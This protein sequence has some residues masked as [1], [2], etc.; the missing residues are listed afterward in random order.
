VPDDPRRRRGHCATTRVGQPPKPRYFRHSTSG[1]PYALL[2]RCGGGERGRGTDAGARLSPF[3]RA[4][5]ATL[6]K[7]DV[8]E[9][10]F[11]RDAY[12]CER[13]T[14]IAPILLTSL[15]RPTVPPAVGTSGM[16]RRTF[17][18]LLARSVIF[19]GPLRGPTP[20]GSR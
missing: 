11:Q 1:I 2:C 18:V 16:N 17:I 7:P 3:A 5:A 19:S 20:G 10:A 12:E 8:D 13:D 4:A 14:A 9:A 6:T 15:I